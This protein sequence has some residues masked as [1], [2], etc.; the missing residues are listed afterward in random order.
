MKKSVPGMGNEGRSTSIVFAA[1]GTGSAVAILMFVVRPLI[2]D[3]RER[4]KAAR[5]E[6]KRNTK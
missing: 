1:A 6:R 4:R 2:R 3:A 5:A